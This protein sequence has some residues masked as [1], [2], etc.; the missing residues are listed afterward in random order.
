MKWSQY[1]LKTQKEIPVDAITASHKLM[2]RTSMVRQSV[3]GIY[4]WLPLG[5]RVLRKIEKIIREEH[6]ESNCIEISMP[7]MQHTSPWIRSGRLDI[8][9][10]ELLRLRD[11]HDNELIYGPTSEEFITDLYHGFVQSYRDAG[12]VLYDIQ[13]KFRD[14]IRPRGG[15]MRGRE[16]LMSAAYS[17]DNSESDALNTYKRMFDMMNR[18]LQRIGLPY[19]AVRADAGE[20]GGDYSH[21]FQM[22][23]KTGESTSYYKENYDAQVQNMTGISLSD[24][25]DGSFIADDLLSEI[26]SNL[27]ETDSSQASQPESLETFRAKIKNSDITIS[28]LVKQ[29]SIEVAHCFYF[30]DKYTRSMDEFVTNANGQKEYLKM[31]SYGVGVSRLVAAI[32]DASHDDKGIIWPISVAPFHVMLINLHVNDSATTEYANDIYNNLCNA[33]VDVFYDDRY[34]SAGIKFHDAD[35]IG[36]PYRLTVSKKLYAE[37]LVELKYRSTHLTETLSFD[38]CMCKIAAK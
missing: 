6:D 8:Y 23:I 32:I 37:N 25:N 29:H 19:I 10:K 7:T 17:F 2:L 14:E 27:T 4:T 34:E 18:I 30:D 15:V 28:N 31:G 22:L 35:L 5:L 21:E 13:L 1:F 3:A 33:G 20:I 16:F 12:C 24:I 11:R 26:T 36:I 9:G 38:E